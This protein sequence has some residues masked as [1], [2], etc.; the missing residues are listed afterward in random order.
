MGQHYFPSDDS[1]ATQPSGSMKKSGNQ[2]IPNASTT[3]LT[4]ETQRVIN[5]ADM[6]IGDM[7][8]LANDEFNLIRAGTYIVNANV[9]FAANA[10][11]YRQVKIKVGTQ[12]VAVGL[13]VPSGST[14]YISA[15]NIFPITGG[16]HKCTVEVIQTSGG[17][18]NLESGNATNFSIKR[19]Y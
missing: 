9:K 1:L 13:I 17:A 19:L 11:G 12:T 6:D 10:N 18:L 8:D 3:K 16:T 15:S 2:S 5:G 7:E 4:W 14:D